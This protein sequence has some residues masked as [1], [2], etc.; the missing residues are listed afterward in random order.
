MALHNCLLLE[1]DANTGFPIGSVNNG[2]VDIHVVQK[3]VSSLE[4]MVKISAVFPSETGFLPCHRE[5]AGAEGTTAA[6]HQLIL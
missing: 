3:L 5:L 1:L 2:A 6:F 4:N